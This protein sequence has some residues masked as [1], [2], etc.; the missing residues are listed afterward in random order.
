M[1]SNENSQDF[2]MQYNP[3]GADI[4]I[5]DYESFANFKELEKLE[6][7]LTFNNGQNSKMEFR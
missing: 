1:A 2:Q 4:T 3:S 5:S 6:C 7:V